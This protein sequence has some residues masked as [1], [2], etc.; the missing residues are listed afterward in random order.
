MDAE[1]L[2]PEELVKRSEQASARSDA[3]TS[4]WD[5]KWPPELADQIV[6]H[7]DEA[8]DAVEAAW[9]SRSRA[10]AETMARLD[11]RMAEAQRR[12]DAM[13]DEAPPED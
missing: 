12:I 5:G 10:L 8:W 1:D 11:A 2:T 9:E 3:I 7:D 13:P 4:E 6:A